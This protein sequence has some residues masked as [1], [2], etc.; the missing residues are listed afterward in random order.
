VIGV[1]DQRNFS[2]RRC[3]SVA[4]CKDAVLGL[5]GVRRTAEQAIDRLAAR[6]EALI[7]SRLVKPWTV[8]IVIA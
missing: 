7:P 4:S 2:S 6:G 3:A 1:E 8:S 5:V